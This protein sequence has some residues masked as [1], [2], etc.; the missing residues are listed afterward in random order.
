M[1]RT[2]IDLRN[3]AFWL[4]D[5]QLRLDLVE[6]QLAEVSRKAVQA[7]SMA[8]AA[9]DSAGSVSGDASSAAANAQRAL[10]LANEANERAKR[11]GETC[12]TMK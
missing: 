2:T 12:C 7:L 3:L 9:Q 4:V 5:R 1:C 8:Q 11:I 6:P 10:D